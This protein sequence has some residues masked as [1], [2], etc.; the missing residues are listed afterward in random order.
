ME[1]ISLNRILH[2]YHIYKDHRCLDHFSHA[3]G[4]YQLVKFNVYM[5]VCNQW[6]GPLNWLNFLFL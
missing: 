4:V 5:A 2:G 3:G 6:T 1:I